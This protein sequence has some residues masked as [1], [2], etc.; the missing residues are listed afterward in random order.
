VPVI[1]TPKR[2]DL[3]LG[4]IVDLRP[5]TRDDLSNV[6]GL[7]LGFTSIVFRP[8][9]FDDFPRLLRCVANQTTRHKQS[10]VPQASAFRIMAGLVAGKMMDR[11]GVI[12]FYRKRVPLAGGISNV[13]LN[14]SWASEYHPDPLLEYIRVSPT[15]PMM[16][17]VFT[18]STR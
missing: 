5:H 1:A 11:N 12:T 6:F 9:D 17:L 7:F 13:N 8:D 14:K 2:Q 16:P 3:A 15:G 4:S 10:G 18:G